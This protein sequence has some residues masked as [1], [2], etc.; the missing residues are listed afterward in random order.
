MAEKTKKMVAVIF[1]GKSVEHDISIITGVQVLS[2]L[3]A[4]KYEIL[5]IYI[6]KQNE[7]YYSQKFFQIT[8]FSQNLEQI[9]KRAKRVTLGQNGILY[10]TRGKVQKIFRRVDFAFLS[11]HGSFGEDG[12]LQGLLEMCDVVYSS[13]DVFGSGVCMS[14]LTTKTACNVVGINTTKYKFVTD[15]DFSGDYDFSKITSELNFPL[16]VKP[17]NL[18]SSVGITFCADEKDLQ[19]ALSFAFLFDSEVLIEEVV[20]NLRELNLAIV[21]NRFSCEISS[22]EEVNL[23]QNFLTFEDKYYEGNKASLG[24]VIPAKLDDSTRE[25]IERYGKI[26]YEFLSLKGVVRIDFLMDDETK[27]VYLNEV[28]TIP[29]SMANYLFKAKYSFG[30]LLEKIMEYSI[31]QKER[32]SQKISKFSSSVLEKF[33]AKQNSASKFGVKNIL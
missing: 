13:P 25:I 33:S 3:D 30:T 17:N 14:K 18:G 22:I 10:I 32:D 21:G 29:G 4:K 11:T 23:K 16:I 28:N 2:N 24:R 12:C 7:W 19:N 5:P 1:G 8:I 9:L 6:T 31:K 15:K 26:I 27:E 20:K